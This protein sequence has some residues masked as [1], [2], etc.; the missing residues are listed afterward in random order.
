MS[1]QTKLISES[2]Q[3]LNPNTTRT[4]IW[5][6]GY[7]HNVYLSPSAWQGLKE[8]KESADLNSIC[9]FLERSIRWL[10]QNPH[11][12]SEIT[13]TP[14]EILSKGDHVVTE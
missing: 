3:G 4:R 8:F 6:R 13:T 5:G 12:V 14:V 11:V 1:L 7:R 9:E 2:Q 10:S